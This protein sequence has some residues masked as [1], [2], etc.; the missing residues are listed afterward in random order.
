MVKQKDVPTP[1]NCL[2][3]HRFDR[4]S[5]PPKDFSRVAD[6]NPYWDKTAVGTQSGH[7]E[8]TLP[9]RVQNGSQN[10]FY[11]FTV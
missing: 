2:H 10:T 7:T 8:D 4:Q 5:P 3:I 9:R 11:F 1:A 6:R